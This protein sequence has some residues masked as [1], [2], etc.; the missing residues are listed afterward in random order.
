MLLIANKTTE[1]EIELISI[2]DVIIS[3]TEGKNSTK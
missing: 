3:T 2:P 1:E